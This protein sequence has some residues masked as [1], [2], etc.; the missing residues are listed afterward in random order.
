MYTL[1]KGIEQADDIL[2]LSQ[3]SRGRNNDFKCWCGKAVAELNS[4]R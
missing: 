2:M 4:K 1:W 3:A